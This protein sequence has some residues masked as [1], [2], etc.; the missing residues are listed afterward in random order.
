M[1][2]MVSASAAASGGPRA[3]VRGGSRAGRHRGEGPKNAEPTACARC[4]LRALSVFRPLADAELAFMERF[5]TGEL[6][7]EPGA[8]ILLEANASPH[9]YT[10]LDGWAVRHKQLEDGRRQVL[11]FALPGDLVGLQA[12]ITN[13]MQHTVTALTQAKLCVFQRDRVWSFF[14][15]FPA[16]GFAMT[17]LAA[18]EEQLLDGHLLSIGQRTALERA[19]YLIL[20]LYDRASVV[21]YAGNDTLPVPFTQAEFSDALGITPVHFSRTLKKLNDRKLVQWADGIIRIRAR[22]ELESIASYERLEAEV[23]PLL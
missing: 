11:N 7:V 6:V 21:D 18:R 4:P 3:L 17:W 2:R 19:A 22:A 13:E 5:K 12:A 20:H 9:L 23:R 10:L 14:K 16:L 8:T 1:K 15:E